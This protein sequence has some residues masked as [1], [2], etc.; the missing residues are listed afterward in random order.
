[1]RKTV[2]LFSAL[3]LVCG[4]FLLSGCSSDSKKRGTK[5]KAENKYPKLTNYKLKLDIISTRANYNRKTPDAVV[6]FSLKNIGANNLSIYEWKM[7]EQENIRVLYAECEKGKAAKVPEENWKESPRR[8]LKIN[9][10]RYP[11]ELGPNNSV[12]VDVPLLF[13]K[14]LEKSGRFAIRGELDLDSVSV[15]S[16]PIEIFVK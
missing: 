4:L 8:M 15:K 6:R 11:L 9:V 12:L 14:K 13:L 1:M 16:T 10:P 7:H 2:F 5:L 3:A